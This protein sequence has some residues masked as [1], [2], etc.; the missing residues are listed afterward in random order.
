MSDCGNCWA[1]VLAAGEGRRLSGLTTTRAGLAI[2][3]QFC[4][5]DGGPSLLHA[6]LVRARAVAAED[7]VC[8]VVAAQHERWWGEHLDSLPDRNV[9]VQPQ[10]RGTANGILLPLLS[11]LSRDPGARIVVLPS[12]HHVQDERTLA[13]SLCIATGHAESSAAQIV[14]LGLKP[15]EPDPELGYIVPGR[16]YGPGYREVER[17]VE[18]PPVPLAQELI[19]RGALWNAFIIAADAQA[20]IK[21]FERRCPDV[22]SAMWQI[23]PTCSG[24]ASHAQSLAELYEE[25][26]VLDFSTRILQGQEHHLHVLP[27]P[28]CGWSDL[29]TPQRVGQVLR[30]LKEHSWRFA[31]PGIQRGPFMN[32]AV[33]YKRLHGAFGPRGESAEK[34]AAAQRKYQAPEIPA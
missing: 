2:P 15:R 24:D 4:S 19:R 33:Q 14:L 30:G 26:P 3:K 7:R 29:G 12:D 5:L 23:L 17:F 31:T 28:E 13:R 20:L 10:N 6:A 25:I 11:I 1:L 22:V 34:V 27:V 18:K 32:L 16:S 8:V 21:L 9:L